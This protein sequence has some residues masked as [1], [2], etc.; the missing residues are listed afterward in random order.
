[1]LTGIALIVIGAVSGILGFLVFIPDRLL[2]WHLKQKE[3]ER[4]NQAELR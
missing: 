1:M 3:K 2:Y 4:E